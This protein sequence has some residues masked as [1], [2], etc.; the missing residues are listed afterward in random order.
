MSMEKPRFSPAGI[1]CVLTA[2]GVLSGTQL[3]E[4]PARADTA[5]ILD[6]VP[7][8]TSDGRQIYER[9]CQGCHMADGKG[10]VGAGRYPALAKDLA[11]SSRQYTAL[12]ILAGR[13]NMPAFGI[14]H[15]VAF[16]GPP[17]SLNETQIAA[18]I[19]YVRTHFENHYKDS[20]TAA[21]VAALDRTLGKQ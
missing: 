10:A 6:S 2:L 21:E 15:A 18:V 12:T 5:G 13:R 19:N 3:I 9:I 16:E 11:L 17:T 8:D 1:V 7:L 14:K 4:S 20:I